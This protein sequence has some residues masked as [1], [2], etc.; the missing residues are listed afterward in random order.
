MR[1]E[2]LMRK[3]EQ[4]A[5]EAWEE[6]RE[7]GSV[8]GAGDGCVGGRAEVVG[9]I[10]AGDEWKRGVLE[11]SPFVDGLEGAGGAGFEIARQFGGG[12][13]LGHGVEFLEGGGKRIGKAPER[14]GLKLFVLRLEVQIMDAPGEMFGNIEFA[15]DEGFVDEEFGGDVGEFVLAPG[16]DLVLHRFEVALHAVDADGDGIDEGEGFGMFGENGGKS[17]WKAILEQTKTR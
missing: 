7:G 2:F 15:F 9:G 11:H 12:F 4:R 6:D 3:V 14:A 16:V 10:G 8:G 13:K 1:A 5:I 17:P